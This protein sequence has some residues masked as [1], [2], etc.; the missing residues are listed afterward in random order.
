[1]PR[2]N[3][4]GIDAGQSRGPLKRIANYLSET[5]RPVYTF[6]LVVPF[7][8]VYE[9][10]LSA[11]RLSVKNFDVRNG[12]DAILRALF[13]P[14]GL[15]ETGTAGTV[16]WVFFSALILVGAFVVWQMRSAA[17]WQMKPGYLGYNYAEA[18]A[19]SIGLFALWIPLRLF[20]LPDDASSWWVVP[21]A[22][23]GKDD[24]GFGARIVMSAGAGVYE[25]LLFRL[26]LTGGIIL[27]LR[28]VL[29]MHRFWAVIGAVAFSS[30]VFALIHYVGPY[31]DK[32]PQTGEEWLGF[33]FRASAGV[34]F[35]LLFFYRSFGMAVATHAFYDIMVSLI[36]FSAA[37]S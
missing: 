14:S 5:Q 25:E 36:M 12:A 18:F 16:L 15:S 32:I 23:G 37:K 35:S 19:W 20:G 8:I 31:G 30:F 24:L 26:F 33:V 22:Q 2:R 7:V 13:F 11:L 28:G 21:C 4:A 29:G 3:D 1:M 9:V 27:L 6:Y 17:S 10:G 34:F